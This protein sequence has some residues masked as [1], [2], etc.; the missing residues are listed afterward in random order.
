MAARDDLFIRI[1]IVGSIQCYIS[2]RSRCCDDAIHPR[3]SSCSCT[4]M[5]NRARH[6]HQSSK[7]AYDGAHVECGG[8]VIPPYR[9]AFRR[10]TDRLKP[11]P[12]PAMIEW[13][14]PPSALPQDIDIMSRKCTYLI[15]HTR[16]YAGSCRSNTE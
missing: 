10:I 14:L 9:L 16:I 3:L 7:C 2:L 13:W 15:T 1:V 6:K 8:S 12:E 4:S 11:T 5:H